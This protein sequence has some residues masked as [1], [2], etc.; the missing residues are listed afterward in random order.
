[1]RQSWRMQRKRRMLAPARTISLSRSAQVEP[2]DAE[3]VAPR[4]SRE[5]TPTCWPDVR[6]K[7][8]APGQGW[9]R[10]SSRPRWPDDAKTPL[11]NTKPV[12]VPTA[13]PSPAKGGVGLFLAR[14]RKEWPEGPGGTR[15]RKSPTP[16]PAQTQPA[17]S[18]IN[19]SQP[20]RP[21]N[22]AVPAQTPRRFRRVR[23]VRSRIS[24]VATA[25]L[26][27]APWRARFKT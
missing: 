17:R 21:R 16:T 13:K 23:G 5:G 22:L 9:P 19:R 7:P 2:R 20:H 14:S 3:G 15:A 24:H 27:D 12:F 6:V 25:P 10:A 26:P 18:R 1:M 11:K 8:G 4:R